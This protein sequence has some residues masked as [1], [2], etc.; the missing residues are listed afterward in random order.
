MAIL[1][2]RDDKVSFGDND[3]GDYIPV[4]VTALIGLW[5]WKILDV[6]RFK[7]QHWKKQFDEVVSQK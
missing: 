3:M 7:L 1:A 6:E 4:H 2:G 5:W